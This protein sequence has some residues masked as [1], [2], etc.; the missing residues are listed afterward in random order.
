MIRPARPTAPRA[1][2]RTPAHRA[3]GS[4]ANR[5]VGLETFLDELH[6]VYRSRGQAVV[7][8]TPPP[9]KI[10]GQQ[11]GGRFLAIHAA[12]GPPDY[13]GAVAGRAVCFDAKEC[14][15]DRW[16]FSHLPAHQAEALS[17][18]EAQG[19]LVFIYLRL[20]GRDHVLPWP[21]LGPLWWAW[22]HATRPGHRAASGSASLSA[23]EV[24]ALGVDV[25]GRGWLAALPE[26]LSLETR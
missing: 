20:A 18:V 17:E 15:A 14:R 3:T 4:E 1:A 16:G 10:I 5:G 26:L 13:T 11:G 8:R 24:R 21:R 12:G 22:C 9:M 23:D 19:G 6:L 25:T 2:R 7:F